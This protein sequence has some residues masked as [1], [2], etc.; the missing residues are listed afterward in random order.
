MLSSGL[1]SRII[2]EMNNETL[3]DTHRYRWKLEKPVSPA[4]L[5]RFSNL[6]PL[7][8]QVLHNRGFE[9]ADDIQAFFTDTVE[10][11]NPFRLQGMTEAVTRIR[12]AIRRRERI[13]VYGDFDVDGVTSTA[14]LIQVLRSLG[15]QAEPYIPHRIEEGYGLNK[16]AL[17]ELAGRRV[18]LVIT[19]DCGIRAIEEVQHGRRLNLDLIITDHHEPPPQLPPAVAVIDP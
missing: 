12:H 2:S 18:S 7:V 3:A 5:E 6:H 8:V 13:A 17:D 15:A 10:D 14:L 4:Q 19:V 11:D 9:E 16:A 1:R